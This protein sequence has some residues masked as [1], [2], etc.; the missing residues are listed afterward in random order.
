MPCLVALLAL[1]AP[2]VVAAVLW[3]FTDFFHRAFLA[4][5]RGLL[6]VAGIVLMPFTTLA[7]AWAINAYGVVDGFP[8]VVIILAVL[9]D[10]SSLASSRRRRA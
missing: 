3:V 8:L 2:R 7:Y 4:P 1:L 9:A 5:G 10:L 6:L